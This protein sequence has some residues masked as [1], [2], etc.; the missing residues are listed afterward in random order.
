MTEYSD[1]SR[2]V[3]AACCAF[4][5]AVL[6]RG[7]APLAGLPV[8]AGLCRQQQDKSWMPTFVGM[9]DRAWLVHR[10][11]QQLLGV[12]YVCESRTIT[13]EVRDAATGGVLGFESLHSFVVTGPA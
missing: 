2:F 11:P 10:L 3:T 6:R 1:A 9:T 4:V 12:A 13:S 7:L 8:T 5:V